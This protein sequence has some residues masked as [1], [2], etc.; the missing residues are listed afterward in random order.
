[1]KRDWNGISTTEQR[2]D[3]SDLLLH[4]YNFLIIVTEGEGNLPDF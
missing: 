4:C 2:T 1:M 3:F